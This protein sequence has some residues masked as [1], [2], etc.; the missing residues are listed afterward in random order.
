MARAQALAFALT[1][2]AK[3]LAR[4]NSASVSQRDLDSEPMWTAVRLRMRM[5]LPFQHYDPHSFVRSANM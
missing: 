5:R 2:V 4:F 1:S 3:L